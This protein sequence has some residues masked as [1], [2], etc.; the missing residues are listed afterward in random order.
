MISYFEYLLDIIQTIF[1]KYHNPN[2]IYR[3]CKVRIDVFL[4]QN[5]ISY[6]EAYYLM[7]ILTELITHTDTS[8]ALDEIRHSKFL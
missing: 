1:I 6:K 5:D 8:I 2:V 4:S 7:S 3:I